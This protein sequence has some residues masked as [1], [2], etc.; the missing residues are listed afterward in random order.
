MKHLKGY[1]EEADATVSKD[2]N[3]VTTGNRRY[4]H[5]EW[6]LNRDDLFIS[7]DPNQKVISFFCP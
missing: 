6:G 1:N 7:C 4:S 3:L 5:L 2:T